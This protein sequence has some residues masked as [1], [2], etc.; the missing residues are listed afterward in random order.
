M[1]CPLRRHQASAF[2]SQCESPG[3]VPVPQQ[4]F[5]GLIDKWES[6][7]V[8]NIF[9]PIRMASRGVGAGCHAG[10][11]LIL[12]PVPTPWKL[13]QSGTQP[14]GPRAQSSQTC[15]SN[16]THSTG[17]VPLGDGQALGTSY[18]TSSF[19]PR[20]TWQVPA[21]SSTIFQHTHV[22]PTP[23]YKLFF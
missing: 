23:K 14:A 20:R 18:T 8:Y 13:K 3:E 4:S 2:F 5:S 21:D 19:G 9:I 17:T 22:L 7:K 15:R 11:F 10:Y 16:L 6:L 1:H 12:R